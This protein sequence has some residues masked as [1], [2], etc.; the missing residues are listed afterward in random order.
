[1]IGGFEQIPDQ[2]LR[3]G[4]SCNVLV[5]FPAPSHHQRTCRFELPLFKENS[6][7]VVSIAHHALALY[8]LSVERIGSEMLMDHYNDTFNN[9][10]VANKLVRIPHCEQIRCRPMLRGSRTINAMYSLFVVKRFFDVGC[11]IRQ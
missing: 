5:V 9:N 8:G 7:G 4:S 2:L 1:M 3:D 6:F 11:T 10:I